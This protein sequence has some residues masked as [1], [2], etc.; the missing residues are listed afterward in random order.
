MK[1][2][3]LSAVSVQFG[4]RLV[5]DDVTWSVQ[6]G[7]R[8]VVLGRN[9]SGK[10][11][12]LRVAALHLH[13]ARGTVRVL[14][15]E[16]GRTDVRVLRQRIGFTSPALADRFRPAITGLD[17]VMTAKYAALEPWWHAYEPADRE[18]AASLLAQMG[19]PAAAS[20]G[21]ATLSSGERQRVLLARLLMTEPGLLLL[22]EPMAGLD[23]GGREELVDSLEVLA[24]DPATAPMVLVTHHL[25]EIPPSFTHALLVS[26][27]TVLAAGPIATVLTS[28][29]VSACFAMDLVVERTGARWLARRGTGRAS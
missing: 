18:R 22:D 12:L 4:N 29:A 19:V 20:Q 2:L 6:P 26:D 23:V 7:E 16:L 14:G 17:V 10:T 13:P 5:L 27:G 21:F 9:G 1:A 25:E 15:E 8:W 28:P 11:T 3:E 24:R